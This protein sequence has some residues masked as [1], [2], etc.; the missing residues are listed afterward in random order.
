M[1]STGLKPKP[2][3]REK[4]QHSQTP[5]NTRGWEAYFKQKVEHTLDLRTDGR[6]LNRGN[7]LQL[8]RVISKREALRE[9]HKGLRSGRRNRRFA[10]RGSGSGFRRT[11]GQS[12]K[13]RLQ[14]L[15]LLCKLRELLRQR[16]NSP[17]LLKPSPDPQ[18]YAA[19][20]LE[21]HPQ[22]PVPRLPRD[23]LN[24]AAQFRNSLDGDNDCAG[25]LFH[26]GKDPCR[27]RDRCLRSGEQRS[28]ATTLEAS[29]ASDDVKSAIWPSPFPPSS[30]FLLLFLIKYFFVFAVGNALS[31]GIHH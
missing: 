14:L 8:L 22:S 7:L 30:S 9:R 13:R 1:P 28:P 10:R 16:H 17:P 2:G 18:S 15:L 6:L 3:S 21:H 11:S 24:D 23:E 19:E 12:G 5:S 25:A 31:T 29:A 4:K 26:F 27:A 20:T